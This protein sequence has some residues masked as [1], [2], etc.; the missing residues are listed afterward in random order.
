[1]R[2]VCT[3]LNLSYCAWLSVGSRTG[4]E[5]LLWRLWGGE[6]DNVIHTGFAEGEMQTLS[7]LHVWKFQED[8]RAPLCKTSLK[9]TYSESGP[10]SGMW[11]CHECR[12]CVYSR[13]NCCATACVFYHQCFPVYPPQGCQNKLSVLSDNTLI[14][15]YG[16]IP[17]RVS[18]LNNKNCFHLPSPQNPEE[19]KSAFH[20]N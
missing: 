16:N 1:M 10:K 6:R 9:H 17:R 19:L 4:L 7:F 20:L 18:L 14:I 8:C 15:F 3:C 13:G 12:D 5:I 2:R 11:M